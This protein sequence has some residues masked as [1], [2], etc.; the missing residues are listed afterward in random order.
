MTQLQYMLNDEHPE[1]SFLV[2]QNHYVVALE[3]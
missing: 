3:Q 1:E 2:Q